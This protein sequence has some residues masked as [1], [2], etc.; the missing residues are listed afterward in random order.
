MAS[1]TPKSNTRSLDKAMQKVV[2]TFGPE[3]VGA[4][5]NNHLGEAAYA[6]VGVYRPSIPQSD[7]IVLVNNTTAADLFDRQ[8]PEPEQRPTRARGLLGRR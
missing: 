8:Q 4:W 5:V 3:A 2:E 6:S 7:A 1:A